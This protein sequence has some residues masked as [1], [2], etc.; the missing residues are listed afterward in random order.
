MAELPTE[1]RVKIL[2]S[3]SELK[4]LTKVQKLAGQEKSDC[5][6][7]GERNLLGSSSPPG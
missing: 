6:R 7:G 4:A 5:L 2:K 3:G 1:A